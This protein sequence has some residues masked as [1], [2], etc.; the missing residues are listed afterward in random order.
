MTIQGHK[1]TVP[2]YIRDLKEG[3]KNKQANL[4]KE[5]EHILCSNR[6]FESKL[7]V[8]MKQRTVALFVKMFSNKGRRTETLFERRFREQNER[9]KL[10]LSASQRSI[11]RGNEFIVHVKIKDIT[12]KKKQKSFVCQ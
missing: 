10:S 12:R 5:G 4:L 6:C 1:D 7:F 11:M 8:H 3:E 9:T 2:A